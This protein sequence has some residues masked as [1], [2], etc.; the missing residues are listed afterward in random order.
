[1]TVDLEYNVMAHISFALYEAYRQGTSLSTLSE[2]LEL[3]LEFIQERIEAA[4]L[5]FLLVDQSST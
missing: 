2:T 5:C 4:R 1:M 3:P